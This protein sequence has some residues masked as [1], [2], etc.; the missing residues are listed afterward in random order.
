ME[1]KLYNIV[2]SNWITSRTVFLT[3]DQ[4]Q[5]LVAA[6]GKTDR[7]YQLAY[8]R[9]QQDQERTMLIDLQHIAIID[10]LN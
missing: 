3:N 10:P 2:M 6:W 7:H 9:T 8:R 5:D 4:Y 1:L